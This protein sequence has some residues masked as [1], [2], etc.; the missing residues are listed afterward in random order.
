MISLN[1]QRTNIVF[2]TLFDED[3]VP[4]VE[5]VSRKERIFERDGI[6]RWNA[7]ASTTTLGY[8]QI[9]GTLKDLLLTSPSTSTN[10]KTSIQSPDIDIS[11]L[12][13]LF[14]K[15]EY[16]LWF[17]RKTKRASIVLKCGVRPTSQLKAW[18]H[19]LMVARR[20]AS[21]SGAADEDEKPSTMLDILESTLR[22]HS[23]MFDGY[24]SRLK[25]AG[26]DVETASL[27]TKPGMRV[28]I[29]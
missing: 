24:I 7:S 26:W 12:V 13:S 6:L 20:V 16:I 9:G 10:Y 5:E 22:Q 28:E 19:A 29:S 1:R 18:S 14:K 3:R 25:E 21:Q 2:S 8:A 23:E 17:D 11:A 15:E 27:E 4:P